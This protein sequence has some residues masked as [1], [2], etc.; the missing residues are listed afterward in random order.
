[1]EPITGI[2]LAGGK[3]SRMGTDKGILEIANKAMI[4]YV[5]ETVKKVTDKIIIISNN[6]NYNQFGYPIYNDLVKEKGPLGGIY[7]GL[8]YSTTEYN[9][10][11]SCDTPLVNDAILKKL[12]QNTRNNTADIIIARDS[13][14]IHPLCGIY[15][16][17]IIEKIKENINDQ[18]LKLKELLVVFKTKTIDFETSEAFTNVNTQSELMEFKKKY[19][20]LN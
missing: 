15:R 2:I 11:L 16:K 19:N 7:T 1:M 3:S 5:I 18:H 14:S 6:N 10:V 12:I 8:F 13:N 17:S 4:S 20:Y 9:L